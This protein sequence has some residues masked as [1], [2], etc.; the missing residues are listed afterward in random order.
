MVFQP[1]G[2]SGFSQTGTHLFL[3]FFLAVS[4]CSSKSISPLRVCFLWPLRASKPRVHVPEPAKVRG[5]VRQRDTIQPHTKTARRGQALT[6]AAAA[7]QVNN[8][9]GQTT[10]LHTHCTSSLHCCKTR[11]GVKQ[12]LRLSVF[13][14]MLTRPQ[15]F[16]WQNAR[17]STSGCIQRQHG[18]SFIWR[19]APLAQ[20]WLIT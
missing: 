11:L 6:H 3:L 19:S 10:A 9:A 5:P 18:A 20:V 13:Q 14:K 8:S 15:A 16:N 7:Q 12:G 2:T 17:N 4:L 1:L